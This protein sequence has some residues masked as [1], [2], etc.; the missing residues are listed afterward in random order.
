MHKQL[1]QEI[2]ENEA[3]QLFIEGDWHPNPLPT[4]I[5]LEEMAYPDT[6]YSFTTFYSKKPVGFKLGYASGNYGHGIFTTGENG[7]INIG[8]FVV[9]QCTR[10]ISNLSVIIKDHCMFSW[11]SVITDS[12]LGLETKSPAARKAMLK[13]AAHS[14]NR[15]LEFIDPQPVTIEEN[16]WVGFEAI[17]LPGVTIGK[18]AVIG[19]KAVVSQDV[20]PYA[21]VVGNPARV[22]KYLDPTDTEQEKEA[23]LR[24]FIN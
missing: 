24:L 16:V 19:C 18:G 15:H 22:I 2:V 1:A 13:Q 21:V 8:K 7:E 11:G 5:E 10:I 20:S 4:N 6:S 3:G 12:W 9:L 17:I 14:Y 23:A